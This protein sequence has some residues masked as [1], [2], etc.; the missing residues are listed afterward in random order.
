MIPSRLHNPTVGFSPTIPLAF[1]GQTIEPFVSVPIVI[2]AKFA[3]AAT[4]DPA[5]DPHGFRVMSYGF[6]V[7]PPRPLHPLEEKSL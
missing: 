5:L 7:C 2:A 1:E 6:F 3:E 4:P